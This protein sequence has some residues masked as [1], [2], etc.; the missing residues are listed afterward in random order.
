MTMFAITAESAEQL[1]WQQLRPNRMFAF[2]ELSSF[3]AIALA[4]LPQLCRAHRREPLCLGRPRGPAASRLPPARHQ[5][6]PA[7]P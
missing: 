7:A 2:R 6:T 1:N 4:H 3:F 5:R